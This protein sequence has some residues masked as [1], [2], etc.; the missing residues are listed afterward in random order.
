MNPTT[1]AA[2]H[3]REKIN[4]HIWPVADTANT[5]LYSGPVYTDGRGN[6]L[7]CFDEGAQGF[8]FV[9]A[10]NM[11][12][13]A[14]EDIADTYIDADFEEVIPQADADDRDESWEEIY[15]VER[16][17]IIAELIGRELAHHVS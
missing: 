3:W 12:S 17:D 9:R 15:L 14:F 1:I 8:Q 6:A 10:C 16:G 2:D 13:T 7:S 5:D 11:V 4:K